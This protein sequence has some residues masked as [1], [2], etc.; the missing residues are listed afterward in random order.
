MPVAGWKVRIKSKPSLSKQ[1]GVRETD[2]SASV[3]FIARNS[4]AD[5]AIVFFVATNLPK[6]SRRDPVGIF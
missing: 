1:V 4:D 6:N 3:I 2:H 5:C